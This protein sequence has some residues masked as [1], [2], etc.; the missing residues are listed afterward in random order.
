MKT[1]ENKRQ[2]D[3]DVESRNRIRDLSEWSIADAEKIKQLKKNRPK[4]STVG[5]STIIGDNVEGRRTWGQ[6]EKEKEE[7]KGSKSEDEN[8]I[9]KNPEEFMD[10]LWKEGAAGKKKRKNSDSGSRKSKKKTAGIES[11]S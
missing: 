4:V 11:F 9:P 7:E 8:G 5:Y 2:Q 10:S 6:K 3:E 1:A